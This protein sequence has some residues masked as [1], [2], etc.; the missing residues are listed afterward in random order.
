M[1]NF[2]LINI[3]SFNSNLTI[4]LLYCFF[5][6]L[7]CLNSYHNIFIPFRT[8]NL[9]IYNEDGQN[10]SSFINKWFYNGIYFLI[11]IRYPL[12]SISTFF[13]TDNSY[14]SFEKCDDLKLSTS[15]T[16][17]KKRFIKS[18]SVKI[19]EENNKNLYKEGNI[20]LFF[21][22]SPNFLSTININ[23]EY[24][25]LNFVYDNNIN[26]DEKLCGNIGLNFNNINKNIEDIDFIEQLKK[27]KIL[28]KYVW[29]LD[30]KT[31]SNGVMVFG[32][33]PHIYESKT[34]NYYQY[35]TIY[36]NLNKN[37]LSWSFNFDKISLNNTNIDLKDTNVELLIDYGLII[38]TEEYKNFIE[39]NYFNNLIKSGI[40][41]KESTRLDIS[42]TISNEYIIFYCDNLKFKNNL[43]EKFNDILL[44][45]KGFEYIF[46]LGK[47]IIFHEINNKVYFLIIFDKNINNKIWKLGEPFLSK[48][49]FVFN[50]EQKT[51]GF[52][53]P[54]LEEKLNDT[55]INNNNTYI[56][57]KNNNDKNNK[58]IFHILKNI[59][60]ILVSIVII[61]YIVK[62]ILN[63]RKIRA[64]ELEDK[65]EYL[66]NNANNSLGI[67][68]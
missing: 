6:I 12:Q 56:N 49:T 66:P 42:K 65:Y 47:D 5:T 16:T 39:Q 32:N 67:N 64:N 43:I 28:S 9:Q 22:D 38:G 29:T 53:N 44:Y 18:I 23:Q 19:K 40:C 21:F 1:S 15:D 24:N 31:R 68:K 14:F 4:F 41:F 59:M 50:K 35:K 55:I 33:E 20:H 52:Y 63:K 51:I 45:Q 27:K 58:S 13:S 61:F 11:Q 54:L 2:L 60:I 62:K 48:Y 25:G 10:T 57:N 36:V 7:N 3:M 17:T 37:K 34:Y 46:K 30:Y 26:E 8:K